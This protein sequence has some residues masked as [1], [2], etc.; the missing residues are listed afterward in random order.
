MLSKVY[1]TSEDLFPLQQSLKFTRMKKLFLFS[2]I[3][4]FSSLIYAQTGQEI[5]PSE[6]PKAT[7]DYI[8]KMFVN[9]S[10]SRA[11]KVDDPK[12]EI[13]YITVVSDGGH[14]YV[15]C[16]DSKGNFVKKADKTMI[17]QYKLKAASTKPVSASP[18]A[19]T[20]PQGQT[21]PAPKK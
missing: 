4:L 1:Q 2:L 5:K 9:C 12:K 10:I 13:T 14:K 20:Q 8:T 15:I 11:A 19:A 18:A 7:R 21:Q 3:C 17:D 16:F 6:L